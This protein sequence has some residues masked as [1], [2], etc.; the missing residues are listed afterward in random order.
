M[1]D[2]DRYEKNKVRGRQREDRMSGR[3]H[4]GYKGIRE[5]MGPGNGRLVNVAVGG[6]GRLQSPQNNTWLFLGVQQT[7][8]AQPQPCPAVLLHHG[9]KALVEEM[10]PCLCRLCHPKKCLSLLPTVH[11]LKCY[12]GHLQYRRGNAHKDSF[13]AA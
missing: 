2:D 8:K 1:N 3:G 10:S 9:I 13:C 5:G 7:H 12:S 6:G 4:D 11:L